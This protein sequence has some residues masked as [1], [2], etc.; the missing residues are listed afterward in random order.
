MS[1]YTKNT[2]QE[3][4]IINRTVGARLAPFAQ[5]CMGTLVDSERD[6][7]RGDEPG[8]R[9][10]N[11]RQEAVGT[12]GNYSFCISSFRAC[13]TCRHFQP[14]VD[15]PHEGVLEELYKEK[16]HAA[17]AGCGREVVNAGDQLILAVEHCVALCKE[18]TANRIADDQP[19]GEPAQAVIDG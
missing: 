4:E 1:V 10:P 5:A 13:Y 7:I 15:G 9:V 14:W 12:C 3:A 2:V 6:A 17:E 19:P 11:H 16:E 18:A 8:S